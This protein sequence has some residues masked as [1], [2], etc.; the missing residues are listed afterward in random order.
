MVIGEIMIMNMIPFFILVRVL[1]I[2]RVR[3]GGGQRERGRGFKW[4]FHGSRPSPDSPAALRT[5]V[6]RQNGT[7]LSA[8]VF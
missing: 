6:S 2:Q 1:E 4:W 5:S 3:L 8:D 7:F